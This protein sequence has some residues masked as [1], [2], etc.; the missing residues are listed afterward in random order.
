ML[1]QASIFFITWS[2]FSYFQ[3]PKRFVVLLHGELKCKYSWKG[4]K[5]SWL[6]HGQWACARLTVDFQRWCM[7]IL[8][9]TEYI[10]FG[11]NG[12]LCNNCIFL[13]FVLG[14]PLLRKFSVSRRSIWEWH[15]VMAPLEF[16]FRTFILQ[17][18]FTTIKS[19][20]KFIF[21]L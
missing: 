9:L 6:V 7:A 4:E 21:H 16:I 2:S 18:L 10:L 11:K 8:F 17:F 13:Y 3:I 12:L 15:G 19:K 20:I 5:F 14:P 1:V